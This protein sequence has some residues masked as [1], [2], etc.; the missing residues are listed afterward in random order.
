M[1]EEKKLAIGSTV[2]YKPHGRPPPDAGIEAGCG[3][4]CIIML[5]FS[6]PLPKMAV[7]VPFFTVC[8]SR[9]TS[10]MNI[11]ILVT[12]L[13]ACFFYNWIKV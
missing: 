5:S 13:F 10:D 8:S 4:W 7:V 6:I 9:R 3:N 12:S 1:K 2:C 11:S